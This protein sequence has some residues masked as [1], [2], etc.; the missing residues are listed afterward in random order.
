MGTRALRCIREGGLILI[1]LIT[2][3]GS[4]LLF[5]QRIEI[6]FPIFMIGY[7]HDRSVINVGQFPKKNVYIY[8]SAAHRNEAITLKFHLQVHLHT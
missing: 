2:L 7:F 6:A 3:E 1:H 5:N 4:M 8:P